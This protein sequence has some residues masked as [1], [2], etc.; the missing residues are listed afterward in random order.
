[1]PRFVG[2]AWRIFR[3]AKG[4][5][6]V[7]GADLGSA[8]VGLAGVAVGSLIAV[9]QQRF[10]VI[11]ARRHERVV[12]WDADR[13]AAYLQMIDFSDQLYRALDDQ[14]ADDLQVSLT[15]VK[16][17]EALAASDGVYRSHNEVR[18]LTSSVA[19]GDAARALVEACSKLFEF[20]KT[21]PHSDEYDQ[22]REAATKKFF[23][24]EEK[25]KTAVTVFIDAAAQELGTKFPKP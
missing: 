8:L 22:A 19:V 16:D 14:D 20:A 15:E 24:F 18:L 21:V 17:R 23:Q 4:Y 7:S 3:S 2:F 25:R 13:R 1:L 11:D 12:R 10:A 5:R 6:S 9:V